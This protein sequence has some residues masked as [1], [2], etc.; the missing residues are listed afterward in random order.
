MIGSMIDSGDLAGVLG[1]Q[2]GDAVKVVE[3]DDER[4]VGD[5][6]RDARAGRDLVRPVSRADLI[7]VG[8]DRYLDRVVVAVVAALDLDDQVPAGNR[9]HQ[10]DRVHGRLGA[11]VGEPP[12]RQAEPAGQLLGDE[13]RAAG[14]LGEVRAQRGLAA[15]GLDDGRVAVPGE[16]GPVPAV[17]VD[18]LVPV[19]VVD[20]GPLA[21][22]EPDR[23]AAGD[24]PA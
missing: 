8:G 5:R 2:A 13:D 19:H 15:D 17:Q 12:L 20:L 1:E 11:R 16:R 24:L 9:A 4:Q 23:L 21:V 18:V 10:V 3:A 22:A 14:R 6:A 7:G